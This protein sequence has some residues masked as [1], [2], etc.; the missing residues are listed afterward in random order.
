M[1]KLEPPHFASGNVKWCHYFGKHLLRDFIVELIRDS[2]LSPLGI[3]LR[4]LK[5]YIHTKLLLSVRSGLIHNSQGWKEPTSL[6]TDSGPPGYQG[7]C[8]PSLGTIPFLLQDLCLLLPF[9]QRD[10]SPRSC[11]PQECGTEEER[12]LRISMLSG[13]IIQSKVAEAGWKS[14]VT[15]CVPRRLRGP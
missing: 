15:E 6:S 9:Q 2:A 5:T 10:R 11:S 13:N 7:G 12:T 1:G 14:W 4:D 8:P 3:C